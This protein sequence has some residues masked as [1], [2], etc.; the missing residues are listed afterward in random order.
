MK[1]TIV[2]PVYKAEK[3][4][5]E[6]VQRIEFS[7]T[8]LTD[9]YEIILV[10]DGSP[11]KSWAVIQQIAKNNTKI[12]GLKLSRNF[13]Q[14]YAITAGLDY[15]TGEWIVVMDCDL[16]DKPE[17]INKLYN[18]AQEGYDI[19]LASRYERKDSFVKRF[20]SKLFYR[21]LGYLTGTIQDESIANFGIY[22]KKVINATQ[23]MRESIR[24]FPTMIKWVGFKQTKVK[25]DHSERYQ[26]KTSYDF[27]RLI[28]LAMDIMLAYSDKP[29]RLS[30]IVGLS[31]SFLSFIVAIIYLIK[32]LSGDVI[33]MG[34]TSLIISVWL[35]AGFIIAILGV[36]GLYVG[37][38]F[39]GV[40]KRPIYIVDET[41]DK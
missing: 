4:L 22:N 12:K 2:S 34:Y 40:K 30:I 11:D 33:I 17:E 13:G 29:I 7:I 10:D 23:T 36:V 9:D 14:H 26:G 8:K 38:T 18:K 31:I 41:T 37:K 19:V 20:L 28:I 32:Y 24:Y 39:E 6:L 1:I 16:Q 35:L 3:I 15:A 21:T 5:S 27:K 25:V